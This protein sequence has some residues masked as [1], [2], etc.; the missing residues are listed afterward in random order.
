MKRPVTPFRPARLIALLAGLSGLPAFA[1]PTFAIRQF[2]VE[3][4]SLL[5]AQHIEAIVKPFTG[6]KRGFGDIQLAL[7]ALERAYRETGYSAVAVTLPEQEISQGVVTFRVVEPRIGQV[8]VEGNQH[9][10]TDN[11]RRSLP[12]LQVG[13]MPHGQ[14]L[15]DAVARANEN[16]AR[17]T[18]VVLK[19]A[20]R[21][22]E[23]DAEVKVEDRK[24]GRFIVN[25][26]NTGMGTTTGDYRLALAW[27]HANLFDRD[28]VLTVQYTTS[29]DHIAD[30]KLFNLGYR[31]PFYGLGHSLDLYAAHSNVDGGTTQVGGLPLAF[32][33][34]GDLVG[35]RYNHHLPR[36]GE[37]EHKL[38]YSLDWRAYDNTCSLGPFGPAGCGAA[39]VDVTARPLSLAY[40]GTWTRPG[41]QSLWSL[42]FTQNLPGGRHGG[43]AA[44]AAARPNGLGA[45]GASADYRIWRLALSHLHILPARW[46]MRAGLYAQ[47]TNDA[48]IAGEQFGLAG[49]NAVRGFNERELTRD[50]AVLVNLELF[51]PDFGSHLP[52]G[53]SSLRAVLFYDHGQGRQVRLPGLSDARETLASAGV[54]LRYAWRK[55]LAMKLDLA[56]VLNAAGSQSSGNWKAHLQFSASF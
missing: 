37:F 29:P 34:R 32:S 33:G 28:H 54:G 55:D 27:Q 47:Y 51:S 49:A 44:F 1:D 12:P 14:R 25:L 30:V 2:A 42:A 22:G 43:D 13:A 40:S 48:L 16:P 52:I 56:N 20:N 45:G 41:A 50:R 9:F 21:P 11:I 31:I 6:E 36:R 23:V 24:P 39:A 7:E 26:D 4:N 46:Q 38:M 53:D 3:G 10:S 8:T 19:I 18:E 5:G 35:L 15:A 17:Q